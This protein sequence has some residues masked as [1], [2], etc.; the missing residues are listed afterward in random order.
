MPFIICR[1]AENNA[2]LRQNK[3]LQG[4][5]LARAGKVR[6]PLSYTGGGG[7]GFTHDFFLNL[8]LLKL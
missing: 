5:H 2:L 4:M 1:A 7:L 3:F 6:V 8:Q